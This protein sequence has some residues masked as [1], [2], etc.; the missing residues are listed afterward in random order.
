MTTHLV[1]Q[2]FVS[3]PQASLNQTMVQFLLSSIATVIATKNPKK[4]ISYQNISIDTKKVF[5]FITLS[6][7]PSFFL[8]PG[9]NTSTVSCGGFVVYFSFLTTCFLMETRKLGAK[10]PTGLKSVLTMRFP[11]GS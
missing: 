10:Q 1:Q 9:F 4:E 7:S 3:N 8:P 11:F 5:S 6:L 2:G